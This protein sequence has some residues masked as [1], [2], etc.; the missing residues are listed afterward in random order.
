MVRAD[1]WVRDQDPAVRREWWELL[2]MGWARVLASWL[3]ARLRETTEAVQK[4]C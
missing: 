3:V 1:P 2:N 4:G